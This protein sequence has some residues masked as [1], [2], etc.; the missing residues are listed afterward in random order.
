[1]ACEGK[2]NGENP[3]RGQIWT[4][5][6]VVLQTLHRTWGWGR[7]HVGSPQHGYEVGIM[8]AIVEIR[9]SQWPVSELLTFKFMLC[10]STRGDLQNAI[11][12]IQRQ[13]TLRTFFC[14]RITYSGS[15][16]GERSIEQWLITESWNQIP[17]LTSCMSTPKFLP[18]LSLS[19]SDSR[20]PLIIFPS[21]KSEGFHGE[22]P[23]NGFDSCR[24]ED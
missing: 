21:P 8:D 18:F 20:M 10:H 24:W 23:H 15:R 9:P 3:I 13:L 4:Y 2:I 1:M 14:A 6:H 11:G 12:S 16:K 19:F 5:I 22:K 17:P 7:V